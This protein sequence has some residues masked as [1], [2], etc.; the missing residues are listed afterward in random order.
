MAAVASR[1]PS[2]PKNAIAGTTAT[3]ASR[4]ASAYVANIAALAS[5]SAATSTYG[6]RARSAASTTGPPV[7]ANGPAALITAAAPARA[8][9]SEPGSST[10]AGRTIAPGNSW[11]SSS[12]RS[13][14]RPETIGVRPR[15]TSSA[16]MKRPVC[17]VAP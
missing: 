17:P 1:S 13:W 3:P 15:R 11:A 14:S 6:I 4:A 5:I 2:P 9:S 16:T 10:V 8:R 12:S 7:T